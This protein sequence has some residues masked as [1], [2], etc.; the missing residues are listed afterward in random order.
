NVNSLKFSTKEYGYN[1]NLNNKE[2]LNAIW[3]GNIPQQGLDLTNY[4]HLIKADSRYAE[5][6]FVAQTIYQQVVFNHYR[7]KDFLVLAPNLSEYETYLT[8]IF[9]QNNISM[10]NDLQ[11]QMK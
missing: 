2:K 4:V 9:S 5:I 3:T 11:K 7:Y 10:F 8:P 6:N 1:I